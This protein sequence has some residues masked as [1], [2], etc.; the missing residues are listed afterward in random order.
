[1]GLSEACNCARSLEAIEN[2]S[3]SDVAFSADIIS[4][5]EPPNQLTDW[6]NEDSHFWSCVER[7]RT[8]Q[9]KEFTLYGFVLSEWVARVPGLYWSKDADQ[10]RALAST[11]VQFQS[12]DWITFE[13]GGKS[14]QVMGGIGTLKFPP[15]EKGYRLGSLTACYN[16]SSGIPVLISPDVWEDHK[17]SEGCRLKATGIWQPMSIGWAERFPSIAGIP[18]EYLVLNKSSQIYAHE[19]KSPVQI[20]PCTVM[21]YESGNSKLFDFVYATADTGDP[22]YRE[23]LQLFFAHYKDDAGRYGRYL[24]SA[25]ISDPLWDAEYSSPEALRRSEPGSESQLALLKARV[26]R[27]SFEGR[28][29]DLLLEALCSHYDNEGLKRLSTMIKIPV[30]QWFRGGTIAEAAAQLLAASIERKNVELLLDAMAMDNPTP[31]LQGA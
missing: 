7:N 21:E 3:L 24:L 16:A 30:T 12:D 20:H 23:L 28:T 26:Q 19:R 18:R 29:L 5:D 4:S 2:Y 31:F 15:D 25:D 1:M 6:G 11:K 10:L 27:L 22:N 9:R 13:P 17:L 14:Y 8:V